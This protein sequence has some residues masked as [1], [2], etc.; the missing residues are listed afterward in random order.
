MNFKYYIMGYKQA[1]LIRQDLKLPKGKMAAQAAHAA[2]EAVLKCDKKIISSWRNDGMAK[3]ALKVENEK[4]LHK[5][6]QIAKDDG[7][8]TST[9]TDAGH[10]VVEPGTVTCSAIGPDEESRID[11]IINQ[12]KLM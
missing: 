3:I 2:V 6:V 4:E 5:Y 1:I 11:K 9:I 12:L 10:T 8:I 7:I